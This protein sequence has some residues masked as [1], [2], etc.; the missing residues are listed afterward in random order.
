MLTKDSS[1]L[2]PKLGFPSATESTASTS[3]QPS[4]KSCLDRRIRIEM[5]CPYSSQQNAHIETQW[6]TIFQIARANLRQSRL[7]L[8]YWE[9]AIS[10]ATVQKNLWP[11]QYQNAYGTTY[12]STPFEEMY[13]YEGRTD[14]LRVF[15][16]DAFVHKHKHQRQ[17]KKFST[18][19]WK[20]AFI[21]L[22]ERKKGFKVEVPS[23][24]KIF[25]SKDVTFIEDS[26]SAARIIRRLDNED[27]D[28]NTPNYQLSDEDSEDSEQDEDDDSN[29][30][31]ELQYSILNHRDKSTLE[32]D[33][34]SSTTSNGDQ[35]SVP[36]N[37]NRFPDH[38]SIRR[39]KRRCGKPR[40]TRLYNGRNRRNAVESREPKR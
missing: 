32:P 25:I 7:P 36:D 6:R 23:E 38:H 15:G 34:N 35:N 13:D 33:K 37:S 10:Y 9:Y 14:M 1:I 28:D 39:N 3:S 24:N 31:E 21:G 5:T 30:Q 4:N 20:G 27:Y 29:D 26:F 22:D 17:D 19:A 18:R 16:C 11:L 8:H 40:T 2:K 12:L